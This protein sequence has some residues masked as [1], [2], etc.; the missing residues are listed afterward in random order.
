MSNQSPPVFSDHTGV[1]TDLFLEYV[2]PT[3]PYYY[4]VHMQ[5]GEGGKQFHVH[6]PCISIPALTAKVADLSNAGHNAFFALASYREAYIEREGKR[7]WRVPENREFMRSFYLDIDCNKPDPASGYATKKEGFHAIGGFL[8]AS[9]VPFP[10]FIVDSGNGFHIYWT[11]Y[12]DMPFAEWQ[13]S[14]N[15]L[16]TLVRAHGLRA[17]PAV[18][19]DSGRVLRPVGTLNHKNAADPKPVKV[20]KSTQPFENDDLVASFTEA[21]AR[22]TPEQLAN[23]V[24]RAAPVAVNSVNAALSSGYSYNK[25]SDAEVI[26]DKC[27]VFGDMRLTKG[28]SQPE[29]VWYAAL[30]VLAYTD[31]SD[32]VCHEWSMGHPDYDR[33]TCQAKIDSAREKS[34][35]TLCVTFQERGCTECA[36]CPHNGKVASPIALG[37]YDRTVDVAPLDIIVAPDGTITEEVIPPLPSMMDKDFRWDD[38]RGLIFMTQDKDGKDVE[39]L[40]CTKAVRADFTHINEAGEHMLRIMIRK[41]PSV[42]VPGDIPAGDL[43]AQS[44]EKALLKAGLT[45]YNSKGASVFMKIWFDSLMAHDAVKLCRQ[46]GWDRDGSF[47]L[48]EDLYNEDGSYI[49]AP[50]AKGLRE[51][52][53]HHIPRGS[54]D[55]QVQLINAVYNHKMLEPFQFGI[56]ASLGSILLP[57]IHGGALGIPYIMNSYTSGS[58]KTKAAETGISLWGDPTEKGQRANGDKFTEYAFNVMAGQRQNMPVLLDEATSITKIDVGKFIYE[59]SDGMPKLQGAKDGGLRDNGMGWANIMLVTTNSSIIS[60]LAA[61]PSYR[62]AQLARIFEVNTVPSTDKELQALFRKT[63]E[64]LRELK[65]FRDTGHIGREFMHFV[66]QNKSG[67]QKMLDGEQA[68]LAMHPDYSSDQRYWIALVASSIV[69]LKIANHLGLLQFDVDNLTQWA[70][71]QIDNMRTAMRENTRSEDEMFERMFTELLPSFVVTDTMRNAVVSK[72]LP[73]PRNVTI[74]GR[75]VTRELSADGKTTSA[76]LYLPTK[77]MDRW[78]SQNA[79]T[80]KE[81]VKYLVHAGLMLNEKKR[82]YLASGVPDVPSGGQVM[83]YHI[84]LP[85]SLSDVEALPLADN[86]LQFR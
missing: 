25:P 8:A 82:T 31:Q 77:V 30:S 45:T 29:P 52:A 21:A 13:V 84:R 78:C 5:N 32:D 11:M 79:Y 38:K 54:R 36:S 71:A 27:A 42:W 33:D 20:I 58:G 74:A 70:N 64:P 28:A 72:E 12:D 50:L 22:L 6:T 10:S 9:G 17:D 57:M 80:T 65:Y 67:V 46:M 73:F 1:T 4:A 24:Q 69:A 86:V 66:I 63:A 83:C 49:N 3:D 51:Y 16:N 68:K 85:E 41:R 7:Q 15:V 2:L 60:M 62:P 14:A 37:S 43:T 76:E 75:C 19:A 40:V 48:G 23:T 35:P 47:L 34:K 53:Q 56:A 39:L 26:A 59:Y 44:I 18:T 81:M 55:K 61:S